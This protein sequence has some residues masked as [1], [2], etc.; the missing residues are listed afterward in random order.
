MGIDLL[1]VAIVLAGLVAFVAGLVDLRAAWRRRSGRA[2]GPELD[3]ITLA[4]Y[5]AL[6][7][8]GLSVLVSIAGVRGIPV[9]QAAF[10]LCAL[11]GV[12]AL[13]RRAPAA[14][15]RA[16]A[17]SGE[18]R[19]RVAAFVAAGCWSLCFWETVFVDHVGMPSFA[20]GIT[21]AVYYL[22][23]LQTGVP[24]LGRLPIGFGDVFGAQNFDFYPTGTHALMAI[25]GGFWGQW[26]LISHA[27]ILK[28][29]FTLSSAAA[30]FALYWF[31]R[32]LM[33]RM[34]WWIGLALVLV[35][36]PG[37]RFP[38]EAIH[39]G[40]ASRLLTHVVMLP[41]YAD[42]LLGR[43]AGWRRQPL[44]A[45][46][47]GVAFLM[48]PAALITL[49]VL[50]VYAALCE[51]VNDAGWPARALRLGATGGALAAAG[52]LCVGLV[53][54]NLFAIVPH[55]GVQ[56]FSWTALASRLRGAWTTLF[57]IGYGMQGVRQWMIGAGLVLLV[58]RRRAFG[59]RRRVAG[60]PFLMAALAAVAVSSL[61]IPLPGFRPVGAAFYDEAPRVIEVLYEVLG[62]CVAAAAWFAWTLA[63]RRPVRT[64]VLRPAL[65]AGVLLVAAAFEYQLA[66]AG[67]V[68]RHVAYWDAW[69]HTPRISVLRDLGEWIQANTEP[70]AIVFHLPFDSEVWEPWTGRQGSF[71]YGECHANNMKLPCRAR[72][73]FV[74]TRIGSLGAALGHGSAAGAC[75]PGVDRFARPA[76]FLVPSALRRPFGSPV[77]ADA[78]YMTTLAGHAVVAYRRPDAGPSPGH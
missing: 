26:G 28:A 35:A 66:R 14:W 78:V 36:M 60:L 43:L 1:S 10:L 17:A 23:I 54:W 71:M 4:A 13:A 29:W 41:I 68:R 51:A 38:I 11:R 12:V 67:E 20:D 63:G 64:R 50:L 47:L 65:V 5:A 59:L 52:L 18:S 34:P 58:A 7:L 15:T 70:D 39:E 56:P 37:F 74:I 77:C 72:T 40:G 69:F 21:H 61:V 19:L 24:T 49:A 76:Y 8:V 30:P 62:L 27:G 25:G 22:R 55:H 75:L 2:A 53:K 57:G 9:A 16:R 42:V 32:R 48:H 73:S 3:A 6:G 45:L 33:P 44:A 31:V 46:L